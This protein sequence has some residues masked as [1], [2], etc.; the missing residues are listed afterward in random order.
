[1]L[2]Q[3]EKKALL[4]LARSAIETK[5]LKKQPDIS[6]VSNLTEMKGC[7]VTI[8]INNQLRGCMGMIR[9]ATSLYETI[10]NTARMAAFQDPRFPSLKEEELKDIKIEI[11]I[12]TRP[13]LIKEAKEIEIGK[14]G[15]IIEQGYHSGLLLPQVFIRYNCTQQ[16]ALEMV[17]EK[18]GLTIDS[19]KQPDTRLYKFEAEIFSE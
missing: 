1:M 7:F 14:D 16:Q 13:E 4:E 19:W 5:F 11:S 9:S 2:R 6:K 10:I 17:C 15:L 12:L 8:E 18:A 3:E